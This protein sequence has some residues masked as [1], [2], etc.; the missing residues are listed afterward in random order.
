MGKAVTQDMWLTRCHGGRSMLTYL[1]PVIDR[2]YGTRILDAFAAV[3]EPT[4]VKHLCEAGVRKQFGELPEML[5]PRRVRMTC[6]FVDYDS[7]A[8]IEPKT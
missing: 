2:I 5:I 8:G 1:K 6:E 7:M 4:E 3:G